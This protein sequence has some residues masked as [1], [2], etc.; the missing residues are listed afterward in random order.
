MYKAEPDFRELCE[1]RPAAIAKI[2]DKLPPHQHTTPEQ[3]T[4]LID[5]A[6]EWPV[7]A[8]NLLKFIGYL[9]LGLGS[10]LG[11]AVT[12]DLARNLR[13]QRTGCL[14]LCNGHRP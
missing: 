12:G 7:D 13:V 2:N 5:N 6:R 9:L 4:Q 8:A 1:G 10:W 14:C 3:I 11:G